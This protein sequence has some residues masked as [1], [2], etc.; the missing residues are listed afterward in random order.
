MQQEQ[1]DKNSAIVKEKWV[2]KLLFYFTGKNIIFY[3][4]VIF[5]YLI[6]E[7]DQST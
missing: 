5:E 2:R 6:L 3:D 1:D 7:E 4:D